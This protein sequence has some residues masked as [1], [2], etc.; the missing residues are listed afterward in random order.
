MGT[1]FMF[2]TPVWTRVRAQDKLD[3]RLFRDCISL[4][5]QWECRVGEP[6]VVKGNRVP[7]AYVSSLAGADQH[8]CAQESDENQGGKGL[9]GKCLCRSAAFLALLL[10]RMRPSETPSSRQRLRGD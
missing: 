10:I 8:H 6:E 3:A 1:L 9:Q 7:A 5:R 2:S 4:G